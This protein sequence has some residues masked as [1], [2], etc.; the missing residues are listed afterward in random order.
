[1][2]A[3]GIVLGVVLPY[4]VGK[5]WYGTQRVTKEKVLVSSAGKIFKEYKPE[6]TPGSIL[7]A[8]STGTEFEEALKGNKAESG[9]SKI[10]SSI[11]KEGELSPLAGGLSIKDREYLENLDEGARRKALALLWAYLGRVDLGDATLNAG[12]LQP[13]SPLP[14]K[15]KR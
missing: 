5:W 9:L 10:E 2:L 12:M 4:L 1:M 15:T 14:A 7:H 11:F 6:M 8:L 13:P 3:Y